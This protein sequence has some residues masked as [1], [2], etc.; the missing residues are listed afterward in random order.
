ME[1]RKNTIRMDKGNPMLTIQKGIVSN[2]ITTAGISLLNIPGTI[3]AILL[4][5][6]LS[7]MIKPETGSYQTGFRP[8]RSTIDNIF[9]VRQICEK[10]Y[11][12]NIDLHNI[13]VDLSQAFDTVNRDVIYNSLI[14]HNV[15]S[16]L[17]KLIKLT[18][19]Q[20]K[21]KLF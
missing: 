5:N 18:L 11:D 20:T 8:N 6:R 21:M 2:V 19:Q 9:I 7:E 17:I 14:K 10:C 15:P 3:F 16:K 13:C 4:Y 12:Y 1:A